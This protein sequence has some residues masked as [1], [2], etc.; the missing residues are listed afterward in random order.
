M[1]ALEA[2]VAEYEDQLVRAFQRIRGDEKNTEKTKRA[3][4]VA[5]ALL[6]ERGAAAPT[7]NTGPVATLGAAKPAATEEAD[8]KT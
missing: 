2:K 3:L 6:D 1:G 5:L 8:L 4:A 7:G